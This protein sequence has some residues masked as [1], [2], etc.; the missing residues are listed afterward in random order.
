MRS[1]TTR[2]P[3]FNALDVA[4]LI[5]ARRRQR[6]RKGP[7]GYPITEATDPLNQFA[8]KVPSPRRDWAMHALHKAQKAWLAAHPDDKGDPSLIWDVEK[9]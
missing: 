1:V 5:E 9:R 8:F 2:E 6:V 3:E 7:H 4:A